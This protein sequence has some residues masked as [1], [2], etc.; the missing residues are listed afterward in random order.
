MSSARTFKV[1]AEDDGVRLDR[2][3][4]RNM[5]GTSHALLSKWARTGLLRVDDARATLGDRLAEGQSLKVPPLAATTPATPRVFQRT[6]KAL[7][8][9]ES[10]F[11]QSMVL[12][13]DD[14]AIVLNK[15]PGL[16]TQGGL[17]LDRHVD[18]LLDALKFDREDR[19]RLVHRLDK[20]TSG[21]LLIARSANAAGFFSKVFSSREADKV[22]W[23]LVKG[24]PERRSGSITLPLNKMPGTGGEKMMVDEANGQTAKTLYRVVE[25]TGDRA[26][27]LELRPL[28]GRTHQLR[29]HCAALGCPIVGDG[30][31]GGAEAYL[32]GGISR[33]LHLHARALTLPHPDKSTLSVLAPLPEHM[34]A[35]WDM[36]GFD[37]DALPAPLPERKDAPPPDRKASRRGERRSR[38]RES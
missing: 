20:D 13:R 22:Y 1:T 16:A 5:P 30:K 31:Y 6:A 35:T 10:E 4:Q 29:V 21:V 37:A 33:K 17:K 7:S 19:P 32:T 14:A 34:A 12:H 23:A 15:P 9:E 28:T 8:P 2:W 26:A 11:A 3:F 25:R 38:G 36:L 24:V 27:W 18:G